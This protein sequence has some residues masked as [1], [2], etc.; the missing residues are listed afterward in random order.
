MKFGVRKPS[1]KRSISARTTGKIKRSVKKAVNP[2]YGKQGMGYINDPKK[3]VYNKVYNKTTVGVKDIIN[4]PTSNHSSKNAGNTNISATPTTN[5]QH[6]C[7]RTVLAVLLIIIGVFTIPVGLIFIAIGILL[8]VMKRKINNAV[9]HNNPIVSTSEHDDTPNINISISTS[10]YYSEKHIAKNHTIDRIDLGKLVG[11]NIGTYTWSVYEISG[12]KTATNRKN[13]RHYNAISEKH[14]ELLANSE[15]ITNIEILSVKPCEVASEAQIKTALDMGMSL[16]D[17]VSAEDAKAII[18]RIRKSE[19]VV[20]EAVISKDLVR[21]YVR[22]TKSPTDQLAKFALEKG[23]VF[24]SYV[25]ED[26]LLWYILSKLSM[27]D[28]LAFYAYCVVCDQRC[29]RIGNMKDSSLF[30]KFYE[31]ADWAA[32]SES[33]VKSLEGRDISDYLKPNKRTSVYR[34][35]MDYSVMNPK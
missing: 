31:F 28:K 19:D 34:A 21:Y 14:V 32:Q 25:S 2:L 7:F 26:S 4:T 22:P 29:E 13:K 6:G 12:I 17:G 35:Y 27:H 5:N 10:S 18:Y 9:Q 30:Q 24:S 16:P 3:A 20:S 33:V 11:E 1:I 8:L 15:G 23:V